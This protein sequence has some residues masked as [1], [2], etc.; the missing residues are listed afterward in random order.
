MIDTNHEDEDEDDMR[1]SRRSRKKAPVVLETDAEGQPL[2]P[3][4]DDGKGLE[5]REMAPMVR[6]Y[7]TAYY[8]KFLD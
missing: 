3:D 5:L 4:P 6:S 7:M 8:S 2:L 1:T